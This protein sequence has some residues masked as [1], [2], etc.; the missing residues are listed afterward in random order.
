MKGVARLYALS[1]AAWGGLKS[2]AVWGEE[3]NYNAIVNFLEAE[4]G[5][6]LGRSQRGAQRRWR[7]KKERNI[8]AA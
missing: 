5:K 7:E 4:K 2:G 6:R 1:S 8:D 3:V